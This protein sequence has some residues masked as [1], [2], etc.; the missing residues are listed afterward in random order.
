MGTLSDHAASLLKKVG[1][2]ERMH[3]EPVQEVKPC[4]YETEADEKLN[5]YRQESLSFLRQL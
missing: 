1:M 2:E 5:L 3:E 4:D